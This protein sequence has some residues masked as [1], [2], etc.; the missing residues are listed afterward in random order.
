MIIG[1]KK[2]PNLIGFTARHG[3][4]LF[5]R[6]IVSSRF[7]LHSPLIYSKMAITDMLNRR[8]RARPDDEDDVYS[9]QSDA[10]EE[11]SQD[12]AEEDDDS[13]AEDLQSHD[14]RTFL[15]LQ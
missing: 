5:F 15:R 12:E 8:V 13:E 7:D 11:P 6:K 9:E 1:G 10:G 4:I 14:V 2:G 3:N